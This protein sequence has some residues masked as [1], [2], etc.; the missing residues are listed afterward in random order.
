MLH[1]LKSVASTSPTWSCFTYVNLLRIPQ[2]SLPSLGWC[3]G[4][5]DAVVNWFDMSLANLAWV[6]CRS[7]QSD[8]VKLLESWRTSGCSVSC[9]LPP[10][11]QA[12]SNNPK[13]LQEPSSPAGSLVWKIQNDRAFST[14]MPRLLLRPSRMHVASSPSTVDFRG[15]KISTP[16]RSRDSGLCEHLF[17]SIS[18]LTV[19]RAKIES[20]LSTQKDLVLLKSRARAKIPSPP[21]YHES[22]LESQSN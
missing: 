4:L 7:T 20:N 5:I 19:Y 17:S 8:L 10:L 22:K 13:I 1:P 11:I 14:R 3:R 9:Y 15:D 12:A 18:L 2:L 21:T 6:L 16:V